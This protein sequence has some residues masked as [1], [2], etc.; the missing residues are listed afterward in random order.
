MKPLLGFIFTFL[1]LFLI[2][3]VISTAVNSGNLWA[4]HQ[5]S[6]GCLDLA[7]NKNCGCKGGITK[8]EY[9]P[10]LGGNGVYFVQCATGIVC[11]VV[12]TYG[13]ISDAVTYTV[14]NRTPVVRLCLFVMVTL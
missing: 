3:E 14:T 6:S 2:S 10:V 1:C 8:L 13:A 9:N 5:P 7:A 4:F 12:A 11:E